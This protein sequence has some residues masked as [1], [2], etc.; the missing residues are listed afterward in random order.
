MMSIDKMEE[1]IQEEIKAQILDETQ[2]IYE[3]TELGYED[4]WGDVP[5]FNNDNNMSTVS[6]I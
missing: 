4:L 2:A 6:S 5:F 1:P 3:E